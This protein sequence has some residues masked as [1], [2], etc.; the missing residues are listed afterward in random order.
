MKTLISTDNLPIKYIPNVVLYFTALSYWNAP[1]WL[2]IVFSLMLVASFIY[3][4]VS[5]KATVTVTAFEK[6]TK[7]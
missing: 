6:E 4:I 2:W 3:D 1:I 5:L 7:K